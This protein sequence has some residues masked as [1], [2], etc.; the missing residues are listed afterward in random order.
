[1]SNGSKFG[2][3]KLNGFQHSTVKNLNNFILQ[4]DTTLHV[5][6][7]LYTQ[8]NNAHVL[9]NKLKSAFWGQLNAKNKPTEWISSNSKY[10]FNEYVEKL[11]N[12]AFHKV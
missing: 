10:H 1:M 7:F 6:L 9:V 2:F 11:F 3:R 8:S 4:F 5:H 12:S